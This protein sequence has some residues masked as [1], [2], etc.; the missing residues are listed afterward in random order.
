MSEEKTIGKNFTTGELI[1]FVSAPIVT[2]LA[3]NL[4]QTLDDGLFLSRYVGHNA[5]AAFSIG[6]PLFM[7]VGAISDLFGGVSVYCSTRMGEGKNKEARGAFTTVAISMT[8]V[9]TAM[10]LVMILFMDPIIRLMGATDILFPYV[11]TFFSIGM[12]YMPL[13]M[14]SF[15]F[16]RFYVPA[17]KPQYSMLTMILSTIC[18]FFFDWL[19]IVKLQLGMAGTA[20]ANLIANVVSV[21]F[22]LVFF[23][24]K[25]CEIGFGKPQGDIWELHKECFS[26]GLPQF[27][28]SVALSMNS[29]IANRVLLNV[30]GEE[31][32]SAYTI[33][34]NIQFMLLGCLFGFS[35]SVCP[36]VS[37]AYGE[38]NRAKVRRLIG[39]IIR[40]TTGLVIIITAIFIL[41]KQF[42]LSLYFKVDTLPAIREMATRGMTVAPLGFFTLSY[43]ILTIDVF[44][45]LND[46]KTSTILTIL[47][48]VVF[49]NL[50]MILL[51][52]I[53]G[54]DGV[55]FTL[56]VSEL[57]TFFF[58]AYFIYRNRNLEMV[59]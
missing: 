33:V 12:W 24:S 59:A 2:R 45:A 48:N 19:F 52:Y 30:G 25:S 18:N 6:M 11:K 50:I 54:V 29:Y 34:N 17:G 44:V 47:E 23:S 51:P 21:V 16:S 26:L 40:L 32:V 43:N 9:G 3:L 28:T 8:A 15:L 49:A 41:G 46:N 38:R 39:Q 5:L 58:T 14:L 56:A 37:Y 36:L 35:G 53:F 31:C 13:N 27:M 22:G 10:I 20:Y 57:L 7:I 42:L 4:L 55:W 1:R